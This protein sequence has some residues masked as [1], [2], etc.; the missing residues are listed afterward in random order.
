MADGFSLFD[1]LELIGLAIIVGVVAYSL[2]WIRAKRNAAYLKAVS[3]NDIEVFWPPFKRFTLTY[4][5]LNLFILL[6]FALMNAKYLAGVEKFD[7]VIIA[8]IAAFLIFQTAL[9]TFWLVRIRKGSWS[10]NRDQII[11]KVALRKFER[12]RDRA[13]KNKQTPVGVFD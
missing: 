4:A 13:S 1:T 9:S 8:V 6:G 7:D 12:L 3:I 5:V 11:A 10:D 2:L